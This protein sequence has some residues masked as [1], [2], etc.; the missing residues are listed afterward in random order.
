M[1]VRTLQCRIEIGLIE[2][3]DMDIDQVS[4]RFMGMQPGEHA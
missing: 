2:K 3:I 1:I 4:P